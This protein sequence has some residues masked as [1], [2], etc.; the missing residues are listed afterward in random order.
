MINWGLAN[1]NGFQNALAQGMAYGQQ[2]KRNREEKEYKNALAGY[3]PSNPETIKPI[4]QADPRLGLQLQQQSAA[5]QAAAQKQRQQDMGTF[6]QL[7]KQ[8][9]QSPE[10]WSQA[11]G[12]AQQLG[13]D[14]SRVP[15]QYNPQWAQEQLFIMDALENPDTMT[16]VQKDIQSLGIDPSTEEGRK[17]VGE[18]ILYKYG[19]PTTD[20]YGR[21][22]LALPQIQVPQG[23]APQQQP[24][25]LPSSSR[26]AGMSDDQL[27][28]QARA[29]VEAGANVDDV[30]RQLKE[31][32][33]SVR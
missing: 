5:Q 14:V 4:M 19:K 15:Q 28:E 25:I 20:E 16:A 22:S 18:L 33:V 24:N 32:G 2:I 10:G 6:R 29:A 11:M 1:Q 31:W 7:L 12:A 3:D 30:F 9:G 8:A 27:F 17:A 26:P 23:Q 21:P 13:L